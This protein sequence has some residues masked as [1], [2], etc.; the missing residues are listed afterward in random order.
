MPGRWIRRIHVRN[1]PSRAGKK[2]RERNRYTGHVGNSLAHECNL[3]SLLGLLRLVEQA[4]LRGPLT[5]RP[6]GSLRMR[7]L[8][9]LT[10]QWAE[11]CMALASLFCLTRFRC[12][13]CFDW[14]SRLL[15]LQASRLST[16]AGTACGHPS[17][18]GILHG[19]CFA[20]L[21]NS[22][23]LLGLLRLVEQAA[24]PTGLA[25][26]SAWGH[27]K[28]SRFDGRASR[29]FALDEKAARVPEPPSV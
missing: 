12:L 28:H 4:G 26:L 17:M 5:Y 20:L 13:G 24:P 9:A 14:W 8:P 15:H 2:C 11:Y 25:T 21:P 16:H 27:C 22:L 18:S 6:R 29:A 19:T 23:S 3:V 7:A 1:N 10:L